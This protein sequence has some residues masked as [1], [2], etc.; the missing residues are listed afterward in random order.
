ME[1]VHDAGLAK[2]IGVSNFR[3]EPRAAGGLIVSSMY[4]AG[5]LSVLA[6]GLQT[7]TVTVSHAGFCMQWQ[8]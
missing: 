4:I 5:G 8:R 3:C 1:E 7:M 6:P 2:A